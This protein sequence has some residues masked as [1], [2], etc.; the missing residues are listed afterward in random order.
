MSTLELPRPP[1]TTETPPVAAPPTTGVWLLTLEQLA[2]I[3][4]GL[5]SLFAHLWML[6]D[7]A[8][9]HDETLHASYSWFLYVGRG[10]IHDPLLHGPLL[11][12][13]GALSYF[14]FGDNDVTARLA[15]A[16]AG[17]A[18]TLTPYLV[19]REIGRGAALLAAIYFLISPVALYVGRFFRHDIYSVLCEMLVF[20]AIVRY[21][22]T[23]Q[24]GWLYVGMA[25]FALM[26]VNQE[27]SYLF[28][29]IMGA[30]LIVP[31][32]WR[33]WRPGVL[34]VGGLALAAVL[35][36][37]VLP[38]TADVDGSNTALR[39]P[40]TGE[41]RHTPG[42]LF[43][44]HPLETDDNAFAL[45]I[46][47]RADDDG[48]RGLLVNLG[49]YLQE[50][51][52]FFGHPAVLLGLGL[53]LG[54]G[55]AI[56]WGTWR[57]VDGE[58]RT[59][60]QRARERDDP[61]A[62]VVAS[63]G[64]GRRLLI[65]LL[66]LLSIYT[67]FFTAFFSN[68]LG[69]ITGTTGSLLYWLAQ[70]N[71]ERGGQP[72]HYYAVILFIYEPLLLIWSA[73]GFGLVGFRLWRTRTA[74]PGTS[75]AERG[76][77]FAVLLL[78]WW[79][80]AAFGIYTWAGE[81]MPWL[82]IH[83]TV[84]LT[85]FSAWA[86]AQT[87]SGVRH[88]FSPQEPSNGVPNWAPVAIYGSL[89]A[90]IVGLSYITLTAI[91]GFGAQSPLPPWAVP[92]FA[93]PLIALL[94]IGAGL[95][96]DWPSALALLAICATVALSLGTARAAY[97]LAYV[98]GDVPREMMVYTQ[99]SPDVM[100]VIRQLEEASIRRGRG[101]AM[102]LLY[103]NETVWTWY[104]RRFTNGTRV[105]PELTAPPADDVMAVLML[106][107][108]LDRYPQN[109]A[110]LDGFV[111]QRYP[112]RWWFPEDQMYRLNSGWRDGPLEGTSL[113]GQALRAPFDPNVGAQVW[114]FLI[115]RD[116]P[117]SIGSTD[118]VIAVRPELAR[119]IGPGFGGSL[120]G[121]AP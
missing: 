97:R 13:L 93:I 49:Q 28:L 94:T 105:G 114:R 64:E 82:S 35:L 16:L 31:F 48:G 72:G 103:D 113:L 21:T 43:G 87:I 2:Y 91:V 89:F 39:D 63:L 102:P 14:L 3:C 12:Y 18:L 38:G 81:K 99:T 7:R 69:L 78:A 98:N 80:V 119:Q 100:H 37:F 34:I 4:L 79:S 62:A 104:L 121:E 52:A 6:G 19:R 11:Y 8:L 40:Q 115:H 22:S 88:F 56:Y 51:S 75:L 71:V 47:N 77:P 45:R 110:Y 106:Q 95:R 41:M 55:F 76:L 42:P 61:V 108:N 36:A 46:R 96:W 54:A 65:A 59:A 74:A 60:W 116:L 86:C 9:H 50:I 118:F 32:L 90:A 1:Q 17:T 117:A 23:R 26:L 20:A 120:R 107:E 112:L 58:G 70:H 111:I 68:M 25:A 5:L 53:A 44:W 66:I 27:T 83:L 109:Q 85:L 15:P 10:Y 33:V 101:L 67:L 30:P 57:R 24:P 29:V 84:P 92:A 73:V